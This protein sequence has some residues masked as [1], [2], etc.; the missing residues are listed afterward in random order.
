MMTNPVGRITQGQFSFL[1]DLSDDDIRVQAQ[2]VKPWGD[3]QTLPIFER[4]VLGGRSMGGRYCSLVV[5]DPDDP[6][7]LDL[8]RACRRACAGPFPG[9][10]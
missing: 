10:S 4:L 6:R 3:T 2:Y 7:R 8:R 9:V 5:A 1:P